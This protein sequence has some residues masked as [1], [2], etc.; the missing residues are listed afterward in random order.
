MAPGKSKSV[1]ILVTFCL[2]LIYGGFLSLLEN[3]R[4]VLGER[5]REHG[6]WD[7]PPSLL[8]AIAVEFKGILASYIVLDAGSRVGARVERAPDGTFV[9]V[10]PKYKCGTLYRMI[11]SSQYLDPAF[12]QSYNFAQGWLPWQPCN[13]VEEC[14]EILETARKNRPWDLFPAMYNAFNHYFFLNDFNKAGKILLEEAAGRKNPPSYLA[15]LGSR[16]SDKGGG[17]ETAITFLES[18]I[19]NTDPDEPGYKTLELRLE[20]LQGVIVLENAVKDFRDTFHMYPKSIMQLRDEGV[21][22]AIP[23]NPYNLDYCVDRQGKVF[24]DRPDCRT[25]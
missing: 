12:Q 14:I 8:S 16:L 13:M 22:S 7:L 18:I 6:I 15:I 4:E 25:N 21:L 24:F 11:K 1:T 5:G 9:T 23:A 17:T 2:I 20:A 10:Q 19:K 3:K